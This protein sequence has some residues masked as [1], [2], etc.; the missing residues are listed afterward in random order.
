MPKAKKNR[1]AQTH[2]LASLSD[3]LSK[4]T[5]FT[6]E[7][8]CLRNHV[9]FMQNCKFLYSTQFQ[10]RMLLLIHQKMEEIGPLDRNRFREILSIVF[11]ITDDV[12]LDLVFRA[13]DHDQ[14]GF[15]RCD[16]ICINNNFYQFIIH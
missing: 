9:Q 7:E 13:F 15:V 3:H 1:L 5:N 12:M 11:A 6:S 4:A 16:K 14:D 8:V 2:K 10:V